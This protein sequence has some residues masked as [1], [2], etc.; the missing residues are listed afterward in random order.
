MDKEH[1]VPELLQSVMKDA[2]S[3]KMVRELLEKA[4]G[5][6][7]VKPR[8]IKEREEHQKTQQAFGQ[9]RGNIDQAVKLYARND[10]EAFF[11]HIGVEEQK[12]LQWVVD[13]L[14]YNELPPDQ[15]KVLDDRKSAEAR[16]LQAEQQVVDLRTDYEKEAVQVRG[17]QLQTVLDRPEISAI[18]QVY[19]SAAGMKPGA[20][21][22]AV[23]EIGDL[24]WQTSKIDLTPEQAVQEVIRRYRLQAPAAAP[25]AT[26]AA[27]AAPAQATAPT[28]AVVP[29]ALPKTPVIPNLAGSST[30]PMKSK[31]RSLAD[32]RK[33]AAE[34]Q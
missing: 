21:R 3:E 30:S 33:I 1:D 13:K 15:R 8:F 4:Y 9:V 7:V 29:A 11:K 12:V 19:E 14:N 27:P 23:A 26:S 28:A 16:A 25:A 34:L 18:A 24:V 6:D 10:M 5:L 31:P 20:F 22:T 32:L 17:L 2:D